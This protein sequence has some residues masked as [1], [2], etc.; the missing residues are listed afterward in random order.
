[1]IMQSGITLDKKGRE[2]NGSVFSLSYVRAVLHLLYHMPVNP[3]GD[4]GI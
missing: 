2:P 3:L 1:M 4:S